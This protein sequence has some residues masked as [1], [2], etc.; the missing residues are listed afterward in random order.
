MHNERHTQQNERETAARNKH[1]YLVSVCM[2]AR[3]YLSIH[4]KFTSMVPN[5]SYFQT[6]FNDFSRK[7][8]KKS[9]F[10]DFHDKRDRWTNQIILEY[11]VNI[12]PSGLCTL[13]SIYKTR[14]CCCSRESCRRCHCRRMRALSCRL[15]SVAAKDFRSYIFRWNNTRFGYESTVLF[16]VYAEH[17][18]C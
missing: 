2:N 6:R 9:F 5:E 16:L 14:V 10:P 3:K 18:N 11:H 4:D 13:T 8:W 15:Q 1:T 17:S 12:P 7:H